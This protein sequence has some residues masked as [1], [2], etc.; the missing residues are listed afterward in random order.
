MDSILTLFLP[1]Y[2]RQNFYI[3]DF[4]CI[5]VIWETTSVRSSLGFKISARVGQSSMTSNTLRQAWISLGKSLN[6]DILFL[7]PQWSSTPYISRNFLIWTHFVIAS[8]KKSDLRT[9]ISSTDNAR[10]LMSFKSVLLWS[11][12]WEN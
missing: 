2:Q 10:K 6:K 11:I 9:H 7:C 12:L 8:W 1:T 4:L 5:L 3:E